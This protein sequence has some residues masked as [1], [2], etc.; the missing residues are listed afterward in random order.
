MG[1]GRGL[2]AIFDLES[3]ED[4]TTIGSVT[5]DI[6]SAVV[7]LELS[8]IDPN[9]DQPR[10]N[11]HTST[12][13]ELA[14]SIASLGIIQPLTVRESDFGR[15]I[16]ISGERRFKAAR[17]LGMTT[18]PVYVRKVDDQQLLEMALVENIQ[19]E[20]LNPLE[21]ALSLERLILECKIT[22]ETLSE[23]VG[24]NRTTISNY[25]RLLRLPSKVQA[26][27]SSN[28]IT[29]G[30][31][32]ALLSLNS[33][34][35]QEMVLDNVIKNSLSVRQTEQVIKT[36]VE[37][38]EDVESVTQVKEITVL[39]PNMKCVEDRLKLLFGS[40]VAIKQT[41]DG[42]GKITIKFNGDDDIDDIA[43]KLQLLVSNDN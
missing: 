40:K 14:K 34:D 28:E 24:K 17:M 33:E 30:H 35:V 3:I 16:I 20:D 12:I 26:A 6:L 36:Y 11:F 27:I 10:T 22:Q 2:N 5:A 8:K 7:E 18:V 23:R 4:N 39:K 38:G 42:K 37:R 29:M 25:I 19:R 41:P 1:L 31:A 32:K 15:Y 9:P 21:I 13:E 43:S